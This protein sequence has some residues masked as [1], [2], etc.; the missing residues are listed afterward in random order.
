MTAMPETVALTLCPAE[1]DN[2]EK[3]L[4]S[5]LFD[6]IEF[7]GYEPSA[8]ISS[9]GFIIDRPEN[10]DRTDTSVWVDEHVFWEQ[11]DPHAYGRMLVQ[12]REM[13]WY[14][15]EGCR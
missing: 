4:V 6:V 8:Y 10:R 1:K 9:P 14:Y 3:I 12:M 13:D 2:G 7:C 5:G 15:E 11:V